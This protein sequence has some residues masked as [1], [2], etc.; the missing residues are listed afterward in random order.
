M[1]VC[2]LKVATLAKESTRRH[3]Q[4]NPERLLP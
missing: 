2:A 3:G 4:T 1:T